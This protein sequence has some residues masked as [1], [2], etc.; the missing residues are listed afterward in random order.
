[1]RYQT[2]TGW[3]FLLGARCGV[4]FDNL[5]GRGDCHDILTVQT[6][7]LAVDSLDISFFAA[8]VTAR[9]FRVPHLCP[10]TYVGWVTMNSRA[11]AVA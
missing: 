3:Y 11:I 9:Y 2:K 4:M 5:C 6:E 1:V 10:L 8:T 7:P